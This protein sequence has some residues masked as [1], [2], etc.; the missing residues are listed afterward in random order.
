MDEIQNLLRTGNTAMR[1]SGNKLLVQPFPFLHAS[2]ES[3]IDDIN[4]RGINSVKRRLEFKILYEGYTPSRYGGSNTTGIYLKTSA[5]SDFAEL[6]LTQMREQML[7]LKL[8]F[9]CL[10]KFSIEA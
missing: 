4:L 10:V 8:E 2:M 5:E 6:I 9:K 7:N 3:F 1:V